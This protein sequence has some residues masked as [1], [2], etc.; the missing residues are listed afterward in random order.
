MPTH[1]P[2]AHGAGA[3]EVAAAAHAE[4]PRR[5]PEPS[6]SAPSE[7]AVVPQRQPGA[8]RSARQQQLRHA[9]AWHRPSPRNRCPRIGSALGSVRRY[10]LPRR[11]LIVR[12]N[13]G[14]TYSNGPGTHQNGSQP[15]F[16][17]SAGHGVLPLVHFV[18]RCPF[19]GSRAGIRTPGCIGALQ[20]LHNVPR[21]ASCMRLIDLDPTETLYARR[22]QALPRHPKA[23]PKCPP[24]FPGR[25]ARRFNDSPTRPFGS[26]VSSRI[27]VAG[28]ASAKGFR[29]LRETLDGIVAEGI[30]DGLS[31]G[32]QH[33]AASVGARFGHPTSV[34]DFLTFGASCHHV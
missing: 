28:T 34:A 20:P 12:L 21:N 3:R 23:S 10:S 2:D 4:V 32:G 6:D 15:A 11:G 33:Y 13:S 29:P 16:G 5:D 17:G 26:V 19:L 22:F 14:S 1:P 18:L 8:A 7:W 27:L 31:P 24:K 9:L 30:W 25:F